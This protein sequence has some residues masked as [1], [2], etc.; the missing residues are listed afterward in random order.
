MNTRLVEE[1]LISVLTVRNPGS[2]FFQILT[3]ILRFY[4]FLG[5]YIITFQSIVLL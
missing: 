1:G 2:N 3:N 4:L 5:V